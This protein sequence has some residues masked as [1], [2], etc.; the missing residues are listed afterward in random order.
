MAKFG[1]PHNYFI[2]DSNFPLYQVKSIDQ[3][4]FAMYVRMSVQREYSQA[5]AG[6]PSVFAI[7]TESKTAAVQSRDRAREAR[8]GDAAGV[9]PAFFH[10]S[11]RIALYPRSAAR[12]H[13]RARST[14]APGHASRRSRGPVTRGICAENVVGTRDLARC[15]RRNQSMVGPDG[16]GGVFTRTQAQGITDMH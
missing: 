13:V 3:E 15:H 4:L 10:P 2:I 6:R 5:L 9:L 1:S 14:T 8:A 12:F 16:I 7:R 11:V